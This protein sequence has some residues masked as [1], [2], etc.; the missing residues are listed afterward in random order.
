MTFDEFKKSLEEKAP[1]EGLGRELKALWIEA[2]GDWD[3]AHRIVQVMENWEAQW[4]HAYLHR[5]EPDEWNARY[6]YNRCGKPMPDSS[7]DEEWEQI[8]RELL[9][10]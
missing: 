9:G 2:N 5:K 3:E 6:W 4:V 7:F 1:P 10:E 8:A